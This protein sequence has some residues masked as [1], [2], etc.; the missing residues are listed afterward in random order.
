L[1]N[2]Y[3][4]DHGASKTNNHPPAYHLTPHHKAPGLI[5]KHE[6]ISKFQGRMLVC[7]MRD[8]FGGLGIR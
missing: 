1:K 2:K 8:H 5:E 3:L 4:A 7:T 6:E